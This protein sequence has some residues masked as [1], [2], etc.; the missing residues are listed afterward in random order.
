MDNLALLS[1]LALAP[2]LVV[3]IL[4]VGFRWPAKYTMPIGYAVVVVVA[5]AVWQMDL[6]S[7]VAASIEGLVI[8]LGLLYI[9]FGALLLLATLT[10]SGA[11]QTIRASFTN[12]SA[13]RRVQAV[14]IGWLFGSFIEG[15]S[16]FGTPAAVVA[17][18]M[19]ALG[20]PAMGAVMVGMVIQSTPVSFGA[21]GTPILVGVA[22]GLGSDTPQVA[23]RVSALGMDYGA[24]VSQIGFEVALLH[25]ITGTLVPVFLCCMLC[26]FYGDKPGLAG[27]ADGLK[28]WPF[29]IFAALAMVVPSVL[30]NYFLTFELT[31]LLGGAIGLAIVVFAAQRGFLLPKDTWD[32]PP[33]E[34]WL[35]KWTGK[36]APGDNDVAVHDGNR[37]GA[38]RA[39]LPYLFIILVILFTRLI[40]PV[41][42]FLQGITVGFGD[43]VTLGAQD[44][45]GTGISNAVAPLY[46]PGGIFLFVV[47]V[48]FLMLRMSPSQMGGSFKLA[49]SQLA[50]AAVALLFAV[51]LVRV[52]INSG[53]D[54][55]ASDLAS[56]PLTLAEGA[57]AMMGAN[58]PVFAPWI[59]ALGAFIAGSNTVSNLTF[60]LFQFETATQIGV[61]PETIVAAQA[62]GGA[63]G[64][65]ITIHNVVAA[66]AVV[67][68]AGREGDVLRQT[69]IPMTYY[70]LM[71]GALTYLFT[72]GPGFNVGTVMLVLVLVALVALAMKIRA[73][74]RAYA[75]KVSDK[76]RE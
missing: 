19:L 13:D 62:V 53:A 75:A 73:S 70:L 57:A 41:E 28:I 36:L 23:E 68:L 33:K 14:I 10:K 67:G 25:A 76:A 24:Y 17:P 56:M 21:V 27:F 58:W 20:F 43:G 32:F 55:N 51:P 69:V 63:A 46:S 6:L 8:A 26:G 16:G 38:I 34:R 15:A 30:V 4:L 29:A 11:I 61:D 49:G 60:S 7:V 3:G 52:F 71:A 59:G 72:Y 9:I 44:I 2:I 39:W 37:V 1:L 40:D 42:E 5:L 35:D 74:G 50:G 48:T 65:M 12:I 64:N 54:H 31:S 18:L 66:S 22:D 45:L 47:L